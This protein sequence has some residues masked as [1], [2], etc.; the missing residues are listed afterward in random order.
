MVLQNLIEQGVKA[1][2]ESIVCTE[3]QYYQEHIDDDNAN[4]MEFDKAY[5]EATHQ[6]KMEKRKLI[7]EQLKD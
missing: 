6:D 1:K 3:D 7:D 2:D 4:I 5:E